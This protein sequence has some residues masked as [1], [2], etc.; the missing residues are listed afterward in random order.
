MDAVV[1]QQTDSVSPNYRCPPFERIALVLQGAG[2]LGPIRVASIRRWPKRTSIPTG[3][4]EFPSA[5]STP[6]SLRETRRNSVSK[7]CA[8]F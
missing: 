3:Y 8:R 2:R 6:P 5:P 4:Q 1:S 7:S